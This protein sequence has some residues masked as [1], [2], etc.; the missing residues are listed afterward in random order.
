MRY[1][2]GV[3]SAISR[4]SKP[5]RVACV[6]AIGLVKDVGAALSKVKGYC[7]GAKVIKAVLVAAVANNFDGIGLVAVCPG[8]PIPRNIR[9]VIFV[10]TAMVANTESVKFKA[11]TIC[12]L[13]ILGITQVSG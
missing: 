8:A 9:H 4:R 13:G 6:A 7:T 5:N 12:E 10:M 1:T 3:V 11:V 2:C